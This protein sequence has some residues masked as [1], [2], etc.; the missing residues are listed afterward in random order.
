MLGCALYACL[1]DPPPEKRTQPTTSASPSAHVRV[2]DGGRVE[3][4]KL[5]RHARHARRRQPSLT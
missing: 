3:M 1:G 5:I 2:A 4:Q